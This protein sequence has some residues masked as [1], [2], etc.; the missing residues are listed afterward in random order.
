MSISELRFTRA[1]DEMQRTGVLGFV[2]LVVD[3][4][5][6]LDGIAVRRTAQGAFVLAFPERRDKS[7]RSHPIVHP[8]DDE[9]REQIEQLVL[10]QLWAL[11]DLP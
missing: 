10:D 11:G 5:L 8:I 2:K 6:V 9:S 1:N 4:W 3:R 7:G